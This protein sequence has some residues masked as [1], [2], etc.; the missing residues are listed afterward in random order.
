MIVL[1]PLNLHWIKGTADD[2]ADLCAHGE[3]DFRIGADVLFGP[4]DDGITV[5]AAALYLMRTLSVSHSAAAPVGDHLFPC[6]G[7]AMYDP[8]D[9]EDV[10]IFGCLDG[11]D[12]E[13]LHPD[14]G[15]EITIRRGE[16]TW[17]VD[18]DH[19]KTAVF[20]FADTV[21]AFYEASSPKEPEPG[22][23]PGF[24]RFL[25]EWQRR[26]G[27]PLYGRTGAP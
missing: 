21:A 10:L 19:W 12:V 3:V 4:T 23:E 2:A 27:R 20:D 5:S 9:T 7:F 8:P 1:R 11:H 16:R 14:G 13:V 24:R 18:P 17:S 22:D 26:R 25:S 6:C 15:H